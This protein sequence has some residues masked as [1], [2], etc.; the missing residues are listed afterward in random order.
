[1]YKLSPSCNLYCWTYACTQGE[2]TR[3]KE[4]RAASFT[5]LIS[6]NWKR[7]RDCPFVQNSNNP[8]VD[9]VSPWIESY[10]LKYLHRN[11]LVTIF[12]FFF[13][14]IMMR[15]FHDE[16][17]SLDSTMNSNSQWYGLLLIRSSLKRKAV[18]MFRVNFFSNNSS[19]L[20]EKNIIIILIRFL[21]PSIVICVYFFY[22]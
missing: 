17:I 1:M 18:R 14:K 15:I 12:F 3:R 16:W 13:S 6:F 9:Q 5:K 2:K 4:Y 7:L 8:F 19:W 20:N 21:S 22:L 10:A 11:T